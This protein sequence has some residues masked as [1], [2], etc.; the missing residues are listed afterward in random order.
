MKLH[1]YRDPEAFWNHRYLFSNENLHSNLG[2]NGLAERC[3]G[4]VFESGTRFMFLWEAQS[5]FRISSTNL[6]RVLIDLRKV[7][8]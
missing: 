4:E 3:F 5:N 1:D 8:S 6:K 2:N 7:L